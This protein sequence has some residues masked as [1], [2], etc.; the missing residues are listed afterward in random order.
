M[1]R[2]G[3][4][5]NR[6]PLSPQERKNVCSKL[7]SVIHADAE[8]DGVNFRGKYERNWPELTA[9]HVVEDAWLFTAFFRE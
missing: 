9:L 1:C 7:H 3:P 2:K 5:D 4:S 6:E 8:E